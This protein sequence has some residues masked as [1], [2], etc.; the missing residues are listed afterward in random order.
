M[1]LISKELFC[2]IFIFINGDLIIEAERIYSVQ[3]I[4]II[5]LKYVFFFNMNI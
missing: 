2:L 4:Y 3:F 5:N 1:L